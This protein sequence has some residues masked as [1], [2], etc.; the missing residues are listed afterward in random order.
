MN[1]TVLDVETPGTILAG[2]LRTSLVTEA[3]A[4][5]EAGNG[6]VQQGPLPYWDHPEDGPED[7]L[8]W[9]LT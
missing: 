7:G 4:H 9:R 1:G 5:A 3:T 6:D 2:T 8:E